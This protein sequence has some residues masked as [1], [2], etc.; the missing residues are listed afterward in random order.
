MTYADRTIHVHLKRIGPAK[1]EK[2]REGLQQCPVDRR[3]VPMQ[4]ANKTA[5]ST[6]LPVKNGTLRRS[7]GDTRAANRRIS[8][9]LLW[10]TFET[11]T[12]LE[13]SRVAP[14]WNAILLMPA[15]Y[16]N[17][18]SQ[19]LDKLGCPVNRRSK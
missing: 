11:E 2:I 4:N 3:I 10:F 13:E 6:H 17:A 8:I 19:H 18:V 5:Q 7:T 14:G 9:F 16:I 12:T 1:G 15:L